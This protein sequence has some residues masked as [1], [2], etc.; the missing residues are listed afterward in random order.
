MVCELYLQKRKRGI[1]YT[2]EFQSS[3]VET[4]NVTCFLAAV[5]AVQLPSHVQLFVR[6][7]FAHGLFVHGLCVCGLF[8]RGLCV[9]GLFARGLCVRGLCVHGL[10]QSRH[11]CSSPSCFPRNKKLSC[12]LATIHEIDFT[13]QIYLCFYRS[14]IRNRN[15]S[16]ANTLSQTLSSP[17]YNFLFFLINYF[18]R[19]IVDLQC[20][21]SFFCILSESYFIIYIYIICHTHTYIHCFL[22]SVPIQVITIQSNERSFHSNPKERQHQR[23]FKLLHKCTHLTHQQSNTQN[24][25]SQASTV[26]EP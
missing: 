4:P 11:P 24:S 15:M 13:I 18:Y 17:L 20:C 16:M 21:I 9:C 7:L 3:F 1:S 19:S 2:P 8:A 14:L 25:P 6:G 10:Q 23:M 26:C 22:D 5:A 12:F